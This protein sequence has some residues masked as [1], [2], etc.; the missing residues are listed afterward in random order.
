MST[1]AEPDLISV[2][3]DLAPI[4]RAN[5]QR[6]DRD[7]RLPAE[8][9]HAMRE[10]GLF[11]LYVPRALGGLQVDPVTHARIQEELSRHDGA[12]G[13]MLQATA[14]S[15][16]W[17]SRLPTETAQ[18]IYADPDTTL[19]VS[20][21]FPFEGEAVDGGLRLSGQRPFASNVSDASWIWVTS[22]T[23]V[24][25]EPMLVD[26]APLVRAAFFPASDAEIVKTW[27]TLGM[28]GTDSNDV[29]VKDLFVPER[30]TFR[31][32]IDHTPGPLYDD[33]LYRVPAMVAVGSYAPAVAL[34]M[35]RDAIDEFVALAQ[36]KTPFAS[37]TTLRERATAQAKLGRAEG[38]LRSAR[39]YLY[40]RL[41]WAWEQTVAGSELTLEQRGEMLLA[42][43]Q[44]VAAATQAVDLVYSAAGTSAIYTRSRIEQHFRDTNVLRQQGFVSESRFETAGQVELGLPPDLGFVAL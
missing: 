12:A 10:A 7:A 9:V 30:R 4:L 18:E 2:A 39:S 24:D 11:R 35:A 19:A 23:L 25:G 6:S 36:G 40:D 33:P 1:L 41:A 21:P 14:S 15:A 16:W 20:F 17:C 43:V 22:L 28:R 8:S 13:W 32:G 37:A 44:A 29:S 26:G 34:G 3:R 42:S 31:I 38:L 27:D 5:S